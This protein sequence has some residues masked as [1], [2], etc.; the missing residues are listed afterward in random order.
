MNAL[1]LGRIIPTIC[2]PDVNDPFIL[3]IQSEC[4]KVI[5]TGEIRC[6]K[7]FYCKI[8]A[9]KQL[10]DGHLFRF[11]NAMRVRTHFNLRFPA[12]SQSDGP[13]VSQLRI[14]GR[15]PYR[16]V[17]AELPNLRF[18]HETFQFAPP[19]KCNFSLIIIIHY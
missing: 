2:I 16:D 10:Q 18:Y 8:S 1:T 9:V 14:S 11:F 6:Q 13:R 15:V 7:T 3:N 19:P 4:Y 17:I 12:W 5:T